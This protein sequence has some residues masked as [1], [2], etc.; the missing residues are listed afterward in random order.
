MNGLASVNIELTN[1]CNKSCWMCGRRK[2]EKEHP[3]LCNWG[4]M[5]FHLLEKISGQIPS[6]VVVQLH[7]NGEPTLYPHLKDALRL[8]KH[9]TTA[10][11]T[12]GSMLLDRYEDIFNGVDSI[13][14]SVVQDDP[15]Q[16]EQM[17]ILDEFLAKKGSARPIVVLRILGNVDQKVIPARAASKCLV[18]RRILH[19]P[20]GSRDY[21]KPVVKPE[22]GICLEA[23]SKLSIDRFGNVSPCVRFDPKKIAVLDNAANVSLDKIWNGNRRR[24]FLEF[25]KSGQRNRNPLCAVCDYWGIPRG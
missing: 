10:F 4:D 13:A 5:D 3:E 11:D 21:E 1:R 19:S 18:V 8:F 9:H 12:N 14:V 23:L 22:I 20:D 17:A 25:H 2:M 24:I 6:D 15:D 7:N 16:A